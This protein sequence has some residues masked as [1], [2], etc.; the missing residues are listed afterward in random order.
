MNVEAALIHA[1]ARG[2]RVTVY[3]PD[4]SLV[5]T[6]HDPRID[7]ERS[8]LRMIAADDPR[9]KFG[10]TGMAPGEGS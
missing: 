4:G 8:W 10:T 6:S 9:V 5:G 3:A 2:E 1:L 7:S